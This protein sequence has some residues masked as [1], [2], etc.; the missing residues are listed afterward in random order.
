MKIENKEYITLRDGAD[1][2]ST[3]LKTVQRWKRE[4]ELTHP[5][6]LKIKG[7][8]RIVLNKKEFMDW[9]KIKKLGQVP[10]KEENLALYGERLK[11]MRLA[12]NEI[13]R[14]RIRA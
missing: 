8:N 13:R 5:V 12:R 4:G 6:V 3:P 9:F 10:T 14:Q 2:T 11:A 1:I 7:S